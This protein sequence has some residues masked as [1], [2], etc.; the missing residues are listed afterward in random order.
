MVPMTV[1]DSIVFAYVVTDIACLCFM[2]PIMRKIKTTFGS[3]ME[4]RLFISMVSF[5][6]AYIVSDA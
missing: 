5:F 4:A 6:V 1:N 2:L 3:E